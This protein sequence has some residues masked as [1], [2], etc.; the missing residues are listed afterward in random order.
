[1]EI[2]I[3]GFFEMEDTN[4]KVFTLGCLGSIAVF[5]MLWVVIGNPIVPFIIGLGLGL[6][7]MW[8]ANKKKEKDHIKFLIENLEVERI[9]KERNEQIALQVLQKENEIKKR[10][11]AE[12]VERLYNEGKLITY[13]DD[14]TWM[15]VGKN[16]LIQIY[17]V[18]ENG[19]ITYTDKSKTH[20]SWTFNE[21]M[22]YSEFS[23]YVDD[24]NEDTWKK[25]VSIHTEGRHI[26]FYTE[27]NVE[28]E[29]MTNHI[30]LWNNMNVSRLN[31]FAEKVNSLADSLLRLEGT[32]TLLHNYIDKMNQTVFLHFNTFLGFE[33]LLYQQFG[34]GKLLLVSRVRPASSINVEDIRIDDEVKAFYFESFTM[35]NKLFNTKINF[36]SD[37]DS[38]LT[39]WLML[40]KIATNYFSQ[41]FESAYGQHFNEVSF[42]SVEKLVETYLQI[43]TINSKTVGN[44]SL[45]TY[46][47]MKKL[48]CS[49]DE[50]ISLYEEIYD[51]IAE[52]LGE[53]EINQFEKSLL[54]EDTP[55]TISINDIDLMDGR[56][57]EHLIGLLFSKMGYST[58]VTKGSGDQGI[59]VIAEKDGKSFGIQTKCYSSVVSNKAIQEVAAGINHYKL[60]KGMVITNNYFTDSARELAQSN[61]VI[62]WDRSILKEKIAE[63]L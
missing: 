62:L 43:D 61:G 1:M 63:L 60:D 20:R 26:M 7:S 41:Q 51:E 17:I 57:F 8:Y 31:N 10:E 39:T 16:A 27:N 33:A 42:E 12:R 53:E 2:G 37:A 54:R 47:Y 23:L 14:C 46:Y 15:E 35:L 36:D 50:Y 22:D 38:A 24:M 9:N 29:K 30:E 45:L 32:Q 25:Y 4:N 55:T 18:F 6:V 3:G 49:E 28:I 19:T 59:D 21:G 48:G 58:K 52:R 13:I 11:E 40:R 44:A 5:I 56:E 34:I